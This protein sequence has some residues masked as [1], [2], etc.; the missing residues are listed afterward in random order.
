MPG[1]SLVILV[2]VFARDQRVSFRFVDQHS[3]RLD[4]QC[5]DKRAYPRA[6]RGAEPTK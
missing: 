1:K 2:L 5:P 6:N 4:V 3:P